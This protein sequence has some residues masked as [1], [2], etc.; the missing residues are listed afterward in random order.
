MA[1][2]H[3]LTTADDDP[4]SK[5]PP[6]AQLTTQGSLTK[7]GEVVKT[8]LIPPRSVRQATATAQPSIPSAPEAPWSVENDENESTPQQSLAAAHRA[9]AGAA[10]S[11]GRLPASMIKSSSLHRLASRPERT[12]SPGL[13][14]D[15]LDAE[16]GFQ[17]LS[18]L[19]EG[20]ED[21][22]NQCAI[23][24]CEFEAG[25]MLRQLPC[26]HDFH[27]TCIDSWML[28]HQTCPLCRYVLWE[29]PNQQQQQQQQDSGA[30]ANP[31]RVVLQVE[32]HPAPVL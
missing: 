22:A 11:L 23:C 5:N 25:E 27:Q 28:Q 32:G 17:N 16:K 20:E 18:Y 30:E 12:A 3:A 21:D 1:A 24:L 4:R 29:D 15:T 13:D 31:E 9:S 8:A 26:Q 10:A 6:A 19:P 7:L 2:T 14:S